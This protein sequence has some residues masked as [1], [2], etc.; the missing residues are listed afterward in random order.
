[1]SVAAGA[2]ERFTEAVRKWHSSVSA[3]IRSTPRL[4]RWPEAG[5]QDPLISARDSVS[6]IQSQLKQEL[7]EIQKIMTTAT[8]SA[9]SIAAAR[10]PLEEQARRL[11]RHVEALQSG[12]GATVRQTSEL[13][14]RK[15]QLLSLQAVA[16]QR[17]KALLTTISR[18]DSSL[19]EVELAREK[20]VKKKVAGRHAA[21]LASRA[22]NSD[23]CHAC[24][25]A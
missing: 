5:G 10:Q 19:D 1:M 22:K 23:Q 3:A 25:A 17:R 21:Q 11:R 16:G 14:E 7:D 20:E 12:A 24:R 4:E 8:T 15:A 6:K 9:E 18:R 13:R 2:F